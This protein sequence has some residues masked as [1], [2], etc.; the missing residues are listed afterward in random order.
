MRRIRLGVFRLNPGRP[1]VQ[2]C[3]VCAS[4]GKRAPQDRATGAQAASRGAQPVVAVAGRH[5]R[6]GVPAMLEDGCVKAGAV[7]VEPEKLPAAQAEPPT[8]EAATATVDDDRTSSLPPKL[9]YIP[10]GGAQLPDE[11]LALICRFLSL[12]DLWRLACVS[13]RFTEP[14]LPAP[15]VL[16]GDCEGINLVNKLSLIEEGAR[17]QIVAAIASGHADADATARLPEDTWLRTLWRA[18]SVLRFAVCGPPT[19]LSDD[20]ASA[21]ITLPLTS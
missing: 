13:Q 9:L 10:L 16:G 2:K 14:T 1:A 4:S 19:E 7:P 6:P 20:R 11:V 5:T 21:V 12:S 18:N 3:C 17:L 15:R 8:A